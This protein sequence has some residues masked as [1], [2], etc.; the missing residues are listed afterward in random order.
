MRPIERRGQQSKVS[1]KGRTAPKAERLGS[2]PEGKL[3]RRNA[4]L[5]ERPRRLPSLPSSLPSRRLV[6]RT[7]DVPP[8]RG[9]LV[10]GR[11][12]SVADGAELGR[13]RAGRTTEAPS[14]SDLLSQGCT[15]QG[16]LNGATPKTNPG[17]PRCDPGFKCRSKPPL[18]ARP[19]EYRYVESPDG[20]ALCERERSQ[21]P[22]PERWNVGSGAFPKDPVAPVNA[23][24]EP[25]RSPRLALDGR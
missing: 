23:S 7:I 20:A 10:R 15:V 13:M 14:V 5:D 19:A 16:P 22:E 21:S 17:F 25:D 24:F 3:C 11:Q 12:V 18:Q 8:E 1:H 9:G 4:R 2:G 6:L